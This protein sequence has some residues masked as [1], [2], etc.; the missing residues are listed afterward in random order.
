[1]D[2]DDWRRSGAANEDVPRDYV[3]KNTLEE[4]R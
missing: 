1:M 3:S 4:H 2:T